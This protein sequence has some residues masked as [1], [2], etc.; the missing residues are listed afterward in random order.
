[1]KAIILAGGEG[2]RLRPITAKMPKPLVPINGIP[3]IELIIGQLAD[4]GITEAAVTT[5]YLAEM[6]EILSA[7][8]AGG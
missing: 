1:M 4:A 8:S 3:A 2:K 7:V 5:G 6:L